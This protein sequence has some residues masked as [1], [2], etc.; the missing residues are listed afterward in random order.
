[1][2]TA[3][4]V[5][6]L[7]ALSG[8]APAQQDSVEVDMSGIAIQFPFSDQV[9]DSI[10]N[11]ADGSPEMIN[12]SDGY[13]FEITG[14][15]RVV[16]FLVEFYNGP[17]GPLFNFLEPGL[18]NVLSGFVRNGPDGLPPPGGKT[19]TESFGGGLF[20]VDI[21]V[22]L[23]IETDLAGVVTVGAVDITSD[24]GVLG[25]ITFS[26][27]TARL[28]KW[29]PTPTQVNEWHFNGDL[30]AEDES[31]GG[32]IRYLDDAAFGDILDSAPQLSS[33][34]PYGNIAFLR[35]DE[36]IDE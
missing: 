8:S 9:R 19:W 22:T 29:E 3:L 6:G 12:L 18:G 24:L 4:T 26:D 31:E 10:N 2:R 27:A 16:V 35:L 23:E 15:A 34:L 30:S 33:V 17:I 25:S 13:E 21:N 28:T 32:A 36:F 5:A 11:P 1:M 14:N 7:L 20:G